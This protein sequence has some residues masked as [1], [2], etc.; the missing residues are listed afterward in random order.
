MATQ[1]QTKQQTL[2]SEKQANDAAGIND[3][4]MMS[5]VTSYNLTLKTTLGVGSARDFRYHLYFSFHK[6][7][8]VQYSSSPI[9]TRQRQ[10]HHLMY[11]LKGLVE[12]TAYAYLFLNAIGIYC[13]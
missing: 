12:K 8:Y 4:M 13:P 11:L 10:Y 7:K 6:Q 5:H 9:F 1:S 3:W 2:S